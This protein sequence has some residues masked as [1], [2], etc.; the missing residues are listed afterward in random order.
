MLL[1]LL[2]QKQFSGL[3]W[4]RKPKDCDLREGLGDSLHLAGQLETQIAL[5][6][7]KRIAYLHEECSRAWPNSWTACDDGVVKGTIGHSP[8]VPLHRTEYSFSPSA[9]QYS[10]DEEEVEKLFQLVL[11]CTQDDPDERPKMLEIVRMID[12][13][14]DR[15]KELAEQSLKESFRSNWNVPTEWILTD[16]SSFTV[17]EELSSPR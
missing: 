15:W 9:R 3:G 16:S 6:V 17:A 2:S 7:A 5:G 8:R 12:G 11:S 14:D 10:R 4:K 13:L 1:K